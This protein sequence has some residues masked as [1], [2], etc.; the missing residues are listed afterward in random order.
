MKNMEPFWRF[1]VYGAG[2][3]TSQAKRIFLAVGFCLIAASFGFIVGSSHVS[4]KIVIA[5]VLNIIALIMIMYAIHSEIEDRFKMEVENLQKKAELDQARELQRSML[6]EG[7]PDHPNYDVA[8]RMITATE[9]GGDYYD[10]FHNEQAFFCVV[11]DATGHG[12]PAGMMVSMT[13]TGIASIQDRE[14]EIIMS[15][16]NRILRKMRMHKMLMALKI[17]KIENNS[18]LISSGGMPPAYIYQS[19]REE[20]IEVDTPA[21]PL[22][23]G[24]SQIYSSEKRDFF[25]DD[26]L[27]LLSDGLMEYRNEND[28]QLGY[29]PVK[30]CIL[31]NGMKTAQEILDELY[32]LG[33]T[34]SSE[35]IQDDMTIMV[36]KKKNNS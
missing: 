30:N 11:G 10:F 26:V 21:M 7:P 18:I 6:P 3:K 17:V 35:D 2:K 8:V 9:V 25:P 22:G 13:K 29:E 4:L 33:K 28:E 23:T 27:V 14:P 1:I 15:R 5:S 31:R 19:N 24:L 16:L 36:I 34:W 32:S 12:L 20:V